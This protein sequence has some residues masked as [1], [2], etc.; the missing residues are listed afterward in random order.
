MIRKD[1]IT[2]VLELINSDTE[3]SKK[4][5]SYL[6]HEWS[7][8]KAIKNKKVLDILDMSFIALCGYSLTSLITKPR[9]YFND[10][11]A[12]N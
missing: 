2:L 6:V 12:W 3:D 4:Q 8:A 11:G 9:K 5:S 1:V 7:K 10:D